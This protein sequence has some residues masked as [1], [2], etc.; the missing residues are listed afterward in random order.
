MAW[1]QGQAFQLTNHAHCGDFPSNIPS[2]NAGISTGLHIAHVLAPHTLARVLEQVP[3]CLYRPLHKYS[4][5]DWIL[6]PSAQ[7]ICNPCRPFCCRRRPHAG[8]KSCWLQAWCSCAAPSDRMAGTVQDFQ[9]QRVQ[10]YAAE[11]E[12]QIRAKQERSRAE[13]RAALLQSQD[14]LAARHAAPAAALPVSFRQADLHVS[15]AQ[16]VPHAE[17]HPRFRNAIESQS[18]EAG[19]ECV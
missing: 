4:A 19:S 17:S 18:A 6:Q 9:K 5:S 7:L 1:D 2:L 12:A 11:L 8:F 10:A 15:T 3:V 14:L 13:R 16:P